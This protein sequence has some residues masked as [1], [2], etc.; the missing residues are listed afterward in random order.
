MKTLQ[1]YLLMAFFLM[2]L[3]LMTDCDQLESPTAP[4]ETRANKEK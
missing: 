1:A 2:G 3:M 4:E